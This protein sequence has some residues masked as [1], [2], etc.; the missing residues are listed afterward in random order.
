MV[1]HARLW[2]RCQHFAVPLIVAFVLLFVFVPATLAATA[3]A[4]RHKPLVIGRS[5]KAATW[6]LVT[7]LLSASSPIS[8]STLVTLT[9]FTVT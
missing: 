5:R 6:L 2:R 7:P 8:I 1:K 4:T 3:T 9:T